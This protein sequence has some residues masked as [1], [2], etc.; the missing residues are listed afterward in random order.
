MRRAVRR[1]RAPRRLL[2]PLFALLP[3]LSLGLLGA[4]LERGARALSVSPDYARFKFSTEFKVSRW[5]Y[6]RDKWEIHGMDVV[7]GRRVPGRIV[8]IVEEGRPAF[9][10][11]PLPFEVRRGAHGYRDGPWEAPGRRRVAVLGDSV[12]FGKGVP[13][14]AR[15]SDLVERERPELRLVNLAIEGCTAA[16]MARI[17]AESAE[18]L[19]PELLLIQASGND[20]DQTLF[21]LARADGLPGLRLRGLS[22]ARRSELLMRALF[23]RGDTDTQRQWAAAAVETERAARPHF[24]A[25]LEQAA[26]LGVPALGIALPYAN[27]VDYGQHLEA[28]CAARPG[29]CLGVLRPDLLSPA[30]EALSAG[31]LPPHTDFVQATA[32][33]MGMRVGDLAPVFPLRHAFVDIVH[34]SPL[35]HAAVAAALLP[36]LQAALPPAPPPADR[37][38]GGASGDGAGDGAG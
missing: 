27:G 2:F 9:D 26:A 11:V 4:A 37:P 13:V 1:T 33:E 16:C 36:A 30:A 8:H 20:L 18:A 6:L 21:H 3:L 28:A 35:G 15:F 34:L 22:V 7:L 32:A 31:P 24:D 25:I 29:T 17:W 5:R 14:E 10:R 23:W 19:R 12:A 38:A